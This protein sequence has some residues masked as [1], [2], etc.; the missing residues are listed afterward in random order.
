[1][2]IVIGLLLL[3]SVAANAAEMG[4]VVR[5]VEL[6]QKPFSDAPKIMD[7]QEKSSVEIVLRQEAWVQVKS[8]DGKVGWVKMLSLRFG[9]GQA[10]TG[11]QVGGVLGAISIFTTGSSGTTTTGGVKGLSEEQIRSASANLKELAKLEANAASNDDAAK[12]AK[13]AK[14]VATSV[15]YL[16]PPKS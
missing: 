10:S 8:K 12:F 6:K 3:L 2:K 1:M 13:A 4:V 9:S 7:L 14:L 5:N 16:P 15:D 11:E